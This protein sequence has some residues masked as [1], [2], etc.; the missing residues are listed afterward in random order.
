MSYNEPEE[1]V[2]TDRKIPADPKSSPAP[3]VKKPGSHSKHAIKA[4]RLAWEAAVAETQ[5]ARTEL[6]QA[7]NAFRAA[8][9]A[10]GSA[11]AHWM[12]LNRPEPDKV[13]REYLARE[14]AMR[15]QNVKAGRDANYRGAAPATSPWPIEQAALNRGRHAGGNKQTPGVPLRSN[16]ARRN[17]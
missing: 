13:V 10:E 4:P 9:T 11:V 6:I 3:V 16:I 2:G 1:F 17:I 8:E 12:S 5:A 14:G 15:E 7:T